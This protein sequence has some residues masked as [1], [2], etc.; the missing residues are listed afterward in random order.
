MPCITVRR[1]AHAASRSRSSAS[2]EALATSTVSRATST[3]SRDAATVSSAALALP[4]REFAILRE[5]LSSSPTAST[6]PEP[7]SWPRRIR[8]HLIAETVERQLA[9]RLPD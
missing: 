7:P 9:A 3:G 2:R 4:L 8:T 6:V 1:N 5:T